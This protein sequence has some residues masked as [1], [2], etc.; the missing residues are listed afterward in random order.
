MKTLHTLFLSAFLVCLAFL[1]SSCSTS[2][3]FTVYGEPGT[4]ILTPSKSTIA[5]IDNTGKVSL[6]NPDDNYYAFLLSH[7][8]GSNDYI[9]FALDYKHKDYTGTKVAR[10]LGF[11]LAG[12]GTFSLTVGTIAGIIG[13]EETMQDV[14]LPMIVLGGVAALLGSGFALSANSRLDQTSHTNSYKYLPTQK[15]NE[16]IQFTKPVYESYVPE[17]KRSVAIT[18]ESSYSNKSLASSSSTKK[19]KDNASKV[20]GTY[21]G[22]GTLK[23]GNE[24][25]EN[26]NDIT[27]TL[28][29]KTKDIVLVNVIESDGSKF[30]S[31]DGEYTIKKLSN[32]KYSLTLKGIKNATIEID[33]R[34]NLIYLH[35]R[36]NIEGDVYTLSIRANKE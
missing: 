3:V 27:V 14:G 8:P 33:S 30:F 21:I 13:G 9:P 20:E 5:T 28:K 18:S 32:G 24:V 34:N 15:T 10:G 23:Q 11:V 31:S 35:P 7:K 12:M 16:D 29:R 6:S 4:E 25:I 17:K 1:A 22:S 26:Y 19:L 2:T 36:V